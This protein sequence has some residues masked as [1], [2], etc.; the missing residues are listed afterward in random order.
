MHWSVIWY[1]GVKLFVPPKSVIS[2]GLDLP[3]RFLRARLII[4]INPTKE[5]NQRKTISFRLKICP[6]YNL[7]EKILLEKN[8]SIK[9]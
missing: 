2:F 8:G 3:Q 1:H 9:I 5:D 7:L 6:K 4:K